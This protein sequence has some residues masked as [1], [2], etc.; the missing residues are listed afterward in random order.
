MADSACSATAYLSGVKANKFTQGVNG[1]VKEDDCE[2]SNNPHNH[3]YSLLRWAQLAG[4]STGVVTNTRVTHASPGSAY[5]HSSNRLH[6]SD[7]DIHQLGAD[8]HACVD[9]A[10]QLIES[11]TGRNLNVIMGGGAIKM[12]PNTT[13]DDYGKRGERRDGRNLI[14][15]W[16]ANKKK[17][18]DAW[19]Y[20]SN[21]NSLMNV[22]HTHVNNLLGLFASGHMQYHSDT[23]HSVEPT[24]TEMTEMAMNILSTNPNGYVL[25]VEGGLIDYA[26][27]ATLAQKAVIE[28]CEFSGAIKM[29]DLKTNEADTM[30]VVTADHAHTMT[31]SGYPERGANI[32]GTMTSLNEGVNPLGKWHSSFKKKIDF[33]GFFKVST[34]P[35]FHLFENHYH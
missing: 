16:I 27:H 8:P 6:E 33:F 18:S 28:T 23:N 14:N 19:A 35:S 30:I 24:L 4:K 32:L 13:I 7:H 2:A 25:F 26:N 5:A 1:N 3:V 20:V 17:E 10:K 29:A 11:E 22:N 21:R 12:L 9:I 15:E 31:I 34:R